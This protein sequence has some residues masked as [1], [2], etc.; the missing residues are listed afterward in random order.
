ML[1]KT[2]FEHHHFLS[3]VGAGRQS[4]HMKNSMFFVSFLKWSLS[5]YMLYNS[6]VVIPLEMNSSSIPWPEKSLYWVFSTVYDV[7]SCVYL[8]HFLTWKFRKKLLMLLGR[9]MKVFIYI[10]SLK[11]ELW[12][13]FLTWILFHKYCKEMSVLPYESLHGTSCV[14][15]MGGFCCKVCKN[16]FYQN[17][18][19]YSHI[20]YCQCQQDLTYLKV[21]FRY[22]VGWQCYPHHFWFALDSLF[23]VF[24]LKEKDQ[25]LVEVQNQG[26][27]S[28]PLLLSHHQVSLQVWIFVQ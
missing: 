23:L 17:S 25:N 24:E 7:L 5:F 4:R 8:I 1:E 10:Y 2:H 21:D 14:F 15:Y 16:M 28:L 9:E 20:V 26:L 11:S 18:S 6:L 3:Y 12:K 13:F 27:F 22:L 19:A